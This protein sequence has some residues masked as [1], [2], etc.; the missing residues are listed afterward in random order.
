MLCGTMV[1]V[2]YA[3]APGLPVA[4]MAEVSTKIFTNP[5]T[6]DTTVP[7][8]SSALARPMPRGSLNPPAGRAGDG[9]A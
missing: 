3:S 6:R 4:P 9:A 7:E 8:A 1:A 5:S 2:W